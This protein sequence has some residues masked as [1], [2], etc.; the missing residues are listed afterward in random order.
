MIETLGAW[1]DPKKRLRAKLDIRPN[2][3]GIYAPF[4]VVVVVVVEE[5]EEETILNGFFY[6][7]KKK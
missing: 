6:G 3:R 4:P 5:E 7:M 1:L 2:I